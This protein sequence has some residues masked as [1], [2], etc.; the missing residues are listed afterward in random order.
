MISIVG[1]DGPNGW[2]GAILGAAGRSGLGGGTAVAFASVRNISTQ[3][4]VTGAIATGGKGGYGGNGADAGYD[5]NGV[6]WAPGTAGAGSPGGNAYATATA[7]TTNGAVAI[8]TGGAA[9]ASGVPGHLLTGDLGT[10]GAKGGAGG[11]ASARSTSYN[12]LAFASATST[13][14]AGAG[15]ASYGAG[16][17]GGAGGGVGGTLSPS[18]AAAG[19]STVGAAATATMS[20]TGGAGGA[21]L[22]GAGGGAGA[23]S[24]SINMVSGYTNSGALTLSQTDIGGA[25]G[26]SIGN[27]AAGGKG[28]AGLSSLTFNDNTSTTLSTV[29][30]ATASATGGGGG[31]GPT[32]GASAAG[33]A[34]LVLT[35]ANEVHGATS[36][37]GGTGILLAGLA[38][39][40]TTVTGLSG[41]LSASANDALRPGQLIQTVSSTTSGVVDGTSA[42][43]AMAGIGANALALSTTLQ[44]VAFI[45]GA[46]SIASAN[47]VLN[48]NTNIKAAFGSAPVFFGIGE[49]GGAY[50]TGA[51]GGSQTVTSSFTETVDLTQLNPLQD[52][53]V[54]F[55]KG[56]AIGTGV[57]G[58][59]FDLYAN[60]TDVVHQTFATAAAAKTYFTNNAIDLGSLASGPLSGPT[61][62]LQATL[63]V[64]MSAAG[65]GFY[66]ELILG[67]PPAAKTSASPNAFAQVMAGMGSNSGALSNAIACATGGAHTT[68]AMPSHF[69]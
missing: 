54:G 49:L 48:S 13:A 5:V 21:G 61:L 31:S 28:G 64:T 38:T 4:V 27:L 14:T 44:G 3:A 39:A 33:T 52:L 68:L 57:T 2:D 6:Y 40:S 16:K 12:S 62:T 66:G 9:G 36:A 7:T 32:L 43:K 41:T 25:G 58:V 34:T 29:I 53:V 22:A 59:T 30:N 56:T 63:S 55:Y 19:E 23:A 60:G 18:M 65:S 67:D 50:S 15:G 69:A 35:G 42:A 26:D 37:T 20:Q 1:S 45:E 11:F 46:P 10:N 47:T 24:G 17:V 51:A 8:G